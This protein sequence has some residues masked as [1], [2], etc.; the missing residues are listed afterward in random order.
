M[1]SR[2]LRIGMLCLLFAVF[3][4]IVFMT[5][6]QAVG[7]EDYCDHTAPYNRVCW[8]VGN[9]L[10]CVHLDMEKNCSEDLGKPGS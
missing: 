7:Q 6:R 5:P 4:C 3:V 2:G 9:D 1:K 10:H 8:K